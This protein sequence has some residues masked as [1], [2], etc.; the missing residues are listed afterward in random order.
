MLNIFVERVFWCGSYREVTSQ[1]PGF[2]QLVLVGGVLPS[3]VA[4]GSMPAG[5]ISLSRRMFCK[6]NPPPALLHVHQAG[7]LARCKCNN[8]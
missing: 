5:W 3:D 6:Q 7:H 4:P 1:M 8:S 2:R